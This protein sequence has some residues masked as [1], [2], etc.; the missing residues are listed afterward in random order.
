MT[1]RIDPKAIA[2]ELRARAET[3]RAMF[4]TD[5]TAWDDARLDAV[6]ADAIDALVKERDMRASESEDLERERNELTA[7][8]EKVRELHVKRDRPAL[9]D[10]T[11]GPGLTVCATREALSTASADALAEHDAALIKSLADAWS[12]WET[13]TASDGHKSI[14][15]HGLSPDD[16]LRSRAQ[17]IREGKTT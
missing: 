4:P 6:A 3:L 12:E 11:C 5:G 17:Q 14:R 8:V 7:V 15:Q 1:D 2:D 16:W 13:F 9:P 10:C